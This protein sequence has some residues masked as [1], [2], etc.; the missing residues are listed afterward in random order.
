MN[1]FGSIFNKLNGWVLWL[2]HHVISKI[3]GRGGE[4]DVEQNWFLCEAIWRSKGIQDGA[5]LVEF[6]TTLRGQAL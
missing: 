2:I 3:L 1:Y 6:Q 5:K 4:E